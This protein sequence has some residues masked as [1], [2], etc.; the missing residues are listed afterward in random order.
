MIKQFSKG[1]GFVLFSLLETNIQAHD[2]TAY[3]MANE[4][5]MVVHGDTKILFDPLFRNSYG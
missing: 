5:L 2:S 4:G 1:I 3:Y